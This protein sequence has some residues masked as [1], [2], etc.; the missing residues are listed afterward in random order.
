MGGTREGTIDDK[1]WIVDD[2]SEQMTHSK[3]RHKTTH[4]RRRRRNSVGGRVDTLAS[5]LATRIM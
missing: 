5:T 3:N 2:N 1:D 4:R